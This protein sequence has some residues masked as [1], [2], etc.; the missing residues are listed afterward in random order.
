MVLD[1]EALCCTQT[2]EMLLVAARA[3]SRYGFREGDQIRVGLGPRDQLT[4][5]FEVLTCSVLGGLHPV[6][7]KVPNTHRARRRAVCQVERDGSRSKP[8]R[9]LLPY[10]EVIAE[11]GEPVVCVA[12]V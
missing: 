10:D 8:F 2:R 4:D 12:H 9:E 3:E 11:P 1:R 5:G 7:D 6:R